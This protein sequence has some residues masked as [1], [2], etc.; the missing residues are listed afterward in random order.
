M[1]QRL[2]ELKDQGRP[3]RGTGGEDAH[4][5]V[6]YNFK[7]TDLQA[8]VGLG[9]LNYL[10]SRLQRMRDIYRWYERELGGLDGIRLLGFDLERGESPQ[11]TDALV[12]RRDELDTF[13]AERGVH[14]RRF[15]HPLHTQAPY[16]GPDRDFP[17]ST[18]VAGR[19]LWLPSAF[20]LSEDDVAVASEQIRRFFSGQSQSRAAVRPGPR[21]MAP[22]AAPSEARTAPSASAVKLSILI[23]VRNEGLNLGV[24]LKLLPAV[25]EVP[26]EVI[27]IHDAPDDDSVPV[28]RRM[29]ANH[30]S[31]KVLHNTL[32]TG[33]INALRAGVAAATGE[34]VLI[35]AADEVGPVLAIDQMLELMDG[36]CEFVSCTRYANGG[37]RLGGS[38][39][40]HMLSWTANWLFHRAAGTALTDATTGIKMFRRSVFEELEL[41]AKPVGWAVAFEMAIKA[42]LAGLKLGEV[43]IISIDRLYGGRSTF[44]PWPWMREYMRWFVWGV[45]R[46][47]G[48]RRASRP[49]VARGAAR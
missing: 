20:T 48:N 49:E 45:P 24:M 42:E 38:A 10:D 23:P 31:L 9:Q 11:W 44:R 13:L 32:G 16:R 36:G 1:H 5:S 12:E 43:P 46:L 30:P 26:H 4:P 22:G 15:W 7:F 47:R 8:A 21:E 33:V 2:R 29:Q 41:A 34:Y 17:Q 18:H 28:V 27:V 19:A 14:C 25:V 35:F 3:F 6:G 37:R 40:S 39:L